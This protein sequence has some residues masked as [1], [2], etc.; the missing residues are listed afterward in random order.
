MPP[1]GGE[2]FADP[3]SGGFPVNADNHKKL[4][5]GPVQKR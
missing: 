5:V 4:L 1:R 2:R 3:D